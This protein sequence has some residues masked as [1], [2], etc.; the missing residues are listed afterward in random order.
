MNY[1]LVNLNLNSKLN[2]LA[3]YVLN[4]GDAAIAFSLLDIVVVIELTR[5]GELTITMS[6]G[7]ESF[8]T[9]TLSS[10]ISALEYAL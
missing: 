6:D 8:T 3:A 9:N 10:A 7:S 2:E 4:N 5:N 1:K